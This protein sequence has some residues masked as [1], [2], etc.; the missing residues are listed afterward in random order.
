MHGP[1][2]LSNPKVT[3]LTSEEILRMKLI[4]KKDEFYKKKFIDSTPYLL[5]V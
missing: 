5:Y 1:I 3:C 2:D 4:K